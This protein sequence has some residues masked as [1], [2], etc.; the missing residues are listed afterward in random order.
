MDT[1]FAEAH[2]EFD[3]PQSMRFTC[4][5]ALFA[6]GYFRESLQL[7]DQL[8]AEL[9]ANQP[10]LLLATAIGGTSLDDAERT[11]GLDSMSEETGTGGSLEGSSQMTMKET[12]GPHLGHSL[13]F[14]QF[15]RQFSTDSFRR[16]ES[17]YQA[18]VG[19]GS[20]SARGWL[21]RSHP[22][23]MAS[24]LLTR[25]TLW[26]TL[27]LAKLL[28]LGEEFFARKRNNCRE[29]KGLFGPEPGHFRL[30]AL[31]LCLASLRNVRG[32]A[33][34]KLLEMEINQLEGDVFA[35]LH[36]LELCPTGLK[37]VRS[38]AEQYLGQ[39][40]GKMPKNVTLPPTRMAHYMVNALSYSHHMR[41]AHGGQK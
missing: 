9:L 29:A 37:I 17:H 28:L 36:R 31:E 18:G 30:R 33:A 15:R 40:C 21:S 11:D 38:L 2:A 12:R 13:R 25:E 34:T 41:S 27:F 26:R 23:L 8:A 10:N 4:C 7:A 20:S 22:R 1:L 14:Q 6:H 39:A 24:S 5:E 32:P 3:D 35:L 16:L 19:G